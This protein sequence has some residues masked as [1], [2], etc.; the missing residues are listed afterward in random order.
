MSNEG[1]L[2]ADIYMTQSRNG[3]LLSNNHF[4]DSKGTSVLLREGSYALAN[5][6]FSSINSPT[7]IILQIEANALVSLTGNQFSDSTVARVVHFASNSFTASSPG[8]MAYNSFTNITGSGSG[9]G[10][11]VENSPNL[12]IQHNQFNSISFASNEGREEGAGL[13]IDESSTGLAIDGNSFAHCVAPIGG[14]LSFKNGFLSLTNNLFSSNQASLYGP[15]VAAFPV[16]LQMKHFNELP[17]IYRDEFPLRTS[18][19]RTLSNIRSGGTIDGLYVV[20][21]D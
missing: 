11:K 4:Q 21:L 5:N 10:V 7:S 2:A 12:V 8:L 3:F 9:I 13:Y 20:L 15:D 6:S 16:A 17:Q 18:L 1:E 19:P 14:A